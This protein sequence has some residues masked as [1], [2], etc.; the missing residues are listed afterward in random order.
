MG[1]NSGKNDNFISTILNKW[2]N[3]AKN[4]FQ[5]LL[6]LIICGISAYK[7]FI[8][9]ILA[10][11]FALFLSFCILCRD[12]IKSCFESWCDLIK[13][14]EDQKT[15]RYTQELKRSAAEHEY[16][17]MQSIETEKEEKSVSNQNIDDFPC[18]PY[19]IKRRKS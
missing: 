15:K 8:P 3:K 13:Y 6:V 19:E 18:K 4:P 10:I 2:M 12:T 14:L 9:L 11:V 5:I 16:A 7:D 17:K 1:D